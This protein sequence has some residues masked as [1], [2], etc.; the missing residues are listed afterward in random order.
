MLSLVIQD[1]QGQA[2]GIAKAK[3]KAIVISSSY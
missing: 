3:S 2:A 1:T